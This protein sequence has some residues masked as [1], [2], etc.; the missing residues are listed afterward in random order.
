MADRF[1]GFFSD[2]TAHGIWFNGMAAP[3]GAERIKIRLDNADLARVRELAN[4]HG[5]TYS[6]RDGMANGYTV[7]LRLRK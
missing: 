3:A 1:D 4:F 7:T 2:L 5:L 6:I